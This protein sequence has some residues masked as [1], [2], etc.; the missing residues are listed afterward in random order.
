MAEENDKRDPLSFL[1]SNTHRLI[2]YLLARQR[3][4]TIKIK[5]MQKKMQSSMIR[6]E[7]MDQEYDLTLCNKKCARCY[8]RGYTAMDTVSDSPIYCTCVI[9]AASKIKEASAK[10]D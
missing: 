8:G 3:R 9:K 4:E 7:V 10:K 1:N 5:R 6:T 2:K